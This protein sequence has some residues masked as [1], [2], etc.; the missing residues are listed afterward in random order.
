MDT[1]LE[2][3]LELHRAFPVVDAHR[4]LAAEILWQNCMGQYNVLENRILPAMRCGGVDILVSSIFIEN[5]YL[6]GQ[7]MEMTYRQIDALRTDIAQ[8]RGSAV[9]IENAAGLRYALEHSVPGIILYCEGLDQIGTDID[10]I[11]ELFRLGVR[12]ASLTWS[13]RNALGQGC[14]RADLNE[15]LT[16]RLS[17]YGKAALSRLESLGMFVDVSH[18]NDDG[19]DDIVSLARRPFIATHSNCRAVH[20]SY[21][22]LRDDQIRILASQGGIT[23]LNNCLNITGA[24]RRR[25][26]T[27]IPCMADHIEHMI[28]TAGDTHAGFGF[29]FCDAYSA[30]YAAAHGEK[31]WYADDSLPGTYAQVPELTAELLRRGYTD[32][33]VARII[34]GNFVSYFEKMLPE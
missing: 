5:A 30:A 24:D 10:R 17:G 8:S 11:D 26:E 4:D 2:R 19:F 27:F 29:D 6:P 31:D 15:D 18:L 14:C 25:S 3:A 28:Q 9:F 21:R 7:G 20:G 34:G 13:R 33:T 12:G 23:G 1:F 16:G 22:N 32:Q